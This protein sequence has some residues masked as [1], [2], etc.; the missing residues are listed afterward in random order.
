MKNVPIQLREL[1]G[2][3]DESPLKN[4]KLR[5]Q[6]EHFDENLDLYLSNKPIVGYILPAYVGGLIESDGVPAHLFRAFYIDVGLFEVLGI[7]HEV[8]P[9]VDELY[10][11]Y[12]RFYSEAN[13]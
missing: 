5:N 10:K 8:Q 7:R 3:T 2:L 9:L 4:R 6:L 11:I 12:G 1:Y 13:T